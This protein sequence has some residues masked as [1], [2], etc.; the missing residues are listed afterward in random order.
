MSDDQICTFLLFFF[1]SRESMIFKRR[2]NKS[3][4]TGR[5]VYQMCC[6]TE[7]EMLHAK[8]HTHTHTHTHAHTHT[9]RDRETER[10]QTHIDRELPITLQ[11]HQMSVELESHLGS[12]V[13]GLAEMTQTGGP[14]PFPAGLGPDSK[15][16]C[17]VDRVGGSLFNPSFL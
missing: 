12:P 16:L 7:Q 4:V 17:H 2:K 14:V 1:G 10:G 5:A 13:D 11:P 9:H 15:R 6:S 3:N 8:T